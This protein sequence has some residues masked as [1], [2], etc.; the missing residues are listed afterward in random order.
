MYNLPLAVDMQEQW[1]LQ[2]SELSQLLLITEVTEVADLYNHRHRLVCWLIKGFQ[3]G[4]LSLLG[5]FSV[6][7]SV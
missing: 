1:S 2:G 6:F 5:I 3:K 4:Q 7:R